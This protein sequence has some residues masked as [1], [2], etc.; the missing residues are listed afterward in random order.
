MKPNV[1]SCGSS[2][3]ANILTQRKNQTSE[4]KARKRVKR[5]KKV[6]VLRNFFVLL[7]DERTKYRSRVLSE[8][9]KEYNAITKGQINSN[10]VQS[11]RG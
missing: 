1:P 9:Q 2:R 4:S 3:G 5:V 11:E 10:T 8:E 7:K 6:E